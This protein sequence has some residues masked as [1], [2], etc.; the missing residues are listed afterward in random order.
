MNEQT[1]STTRTVLTKMRNSAIKIK[2]WMSVVKVLSGTDIS[3]MRQNS[4]R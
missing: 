1:Q 4:F 2:F 3:G